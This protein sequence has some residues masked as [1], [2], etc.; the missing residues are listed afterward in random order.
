MSKLSELDQ[1]SQALIV[2]ASRFSGLFEICLDLLDCARECHADYVEVELRKTD[3]IEIRH[4]GGGPVMQQAKLWEKLQLLARIARLRVYTKNENGCERYDF[5]TE[6]ACPSNLLLK[7]GCILQASSIFEALPSRRAVLLALENQETR[8]EA[9]FNMFC[10]ENQK[11]TLKLYKQGVV[12]SSYEKQPFS[13]RLF[14]VTH[15]ACQ[16]Q[17]LSLVTETLAI[18]GLITAPVDCLHH[19]RMQYWFHQGRIFESECLSDCVNSIYKEAVSLLNTNHTEGVA[20]SKSYKK[21]PVFAIEISS[22]SIEVVHE[23]VHAKALITSDGIVEGLKQAVGAALLSVSPVFKNLSLFQ[24]DSTCRK[25]KRGRKGCAKTFSF[26]AEVDDETLFR[27]LE[28]KE[29]DEVPAKKPKLQTN[30]PK[31][32]PSKIT[33]DLTD[34]IIAVSKLQK[35]IGMLLPRD[36]KHLKEKDVQ[37]HGSF[38]VTTALPTQLPCDLS[39]LEVVCQ[40]HSKFIIARVKASRSCIFAVD[41]HAAH[42]RV[43]LEKYQSQM[44]HALEAEEVSDVITVDA[45]DVET[46][47][48]KEAELKKWNWDFALLTQSK[49]KVTK[50]PKFMG[51][52]IPSDQLPIFASQVVVFPQLLLRLLKFKA[53]RNA[54]KFGEALSADQC[55]NLL[56]DLSSCALAFECAHGRPTMHPLQ[57]PSVTVRKK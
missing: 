28:E 4:N 51:T 39:S 46:L 49:V 31:V 47:I 16:M 21:Y 5:L 18:R 34:S 40:V 45:A 7:P 55:R 20:A 8:V 29:E 1:R 56:N 27:R 32:A 43:L 26:M 48:A 11:M 35:P 19:R 36:L 37:C 3:L 22:D 9:A 25:R 52:A 50:A 10:L 38:P 54:I 33:S 23:G 14:S 53:C 13:S 30:Q 17:R 24:K 57:V 44:P 6:K 15:V 41:Q 2:A 12:A 42:E